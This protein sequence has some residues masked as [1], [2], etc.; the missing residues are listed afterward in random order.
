MYIESKGDGLAGTGWIGRVRFSH[1][2][3]TLYYGK[4]ELHT[5]SGM[6]YKANYFDVNSG[7]RYWVSGPRKD[8]NDSLYPAV[9]TVDEDVREVYWTEV[10]GLPERKAESHYR[11]PGKYSKRKPATPITKSLASRRS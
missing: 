9:I 8:G 11:S 2:G 3:K 1:T 7:E 5:L 10:R 6:G 4:L